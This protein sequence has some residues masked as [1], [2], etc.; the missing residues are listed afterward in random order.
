MVGVGVGVGW[1][2]GERVRKGQ[3]SRREWRRGKEEKKG[4]VK[5]EGADGRF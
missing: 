2:G 3:G 1:G 5:E 4:R